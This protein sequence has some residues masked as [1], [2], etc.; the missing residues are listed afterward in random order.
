MWWNEY[1]P[2]P[3]M[4]FGPGMMIIFV[5]ACFVLAGFMMRGGHRPQRGGA[6]E[7]LRERYARGEI[8]E[9]EFEQ[10]RRLLEQ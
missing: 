2:G 8:N 9:A 4:L 6:L 10:R 1:W 3:W 5:L 7:I